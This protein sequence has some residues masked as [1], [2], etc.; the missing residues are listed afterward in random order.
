M[1]SYNFYV[2]M[3]MYVR[4][5][6]MKHSC[7]LVLIFHLFSGIHYIADCWHSSKSTFISSAMF[8]AYGC[9]LLLSMDIKVWGC[10]CQQ[11]TVL[12]WQSIAIVFIDWAYNVFVFQS[13]AFCIFMLWQHSFYP[14]FLSPFSTHRIGFHISDS[15]FSNCW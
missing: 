2:L 15:Y 8:S 7:M 10:A 6:P 1:I 13:S 3:L 4:L 9:A 11:Y 5:K 12:T 14:P